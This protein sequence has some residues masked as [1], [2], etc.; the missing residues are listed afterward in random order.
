VAEE[1]AGAEQR[2]NARCG[3]WGGVRIGE[4]TGKMRQSSLEGA[5]EIRLSDG[6]KVEGWQKGRGEARALV[7]G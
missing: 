1:F 2:V 7:A 3:G 5:R 6:L 4:S